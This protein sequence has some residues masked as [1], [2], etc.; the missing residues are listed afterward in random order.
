[1]KIFEVGGAVRDRLL[2]LPVKDH[3]YVVVGS[4]PQ[5]MARL[6]YTPVGKDFPVFLHPQTHEEYA[7]ARIERKSAPGYKGFQVYAAPDVTLEQDLSRRDFTI[8]AMARDADGTLVDPY[9]GQADLGAGVLRHVGTAF[10]ED[11]VR[12]LRGARFAARFGFNVAPETLALMRSMAASGEVDAL[13]P[14]RVWQE[15]AKGLMEKAPA[16]MFEVLAQ[17]GALD[18]IFPEAAARA[19]DLRAALKGLSHAVRCDFPLPVR[20][21]ACALGLAGDRTEA[22]AQRVKAPGD[23]RDLAVL[24]AGLHARI[25]AAETAAVEELLALLHAGDAFRRPERYAGLLDVCVCE[26]VR[27]TDAPAEPWPPRVRVELALSAAT[28]VDAGAVAKAGPSG[29]IQARVQAARLDA[30][31][32]ALAGAGIAPAARHN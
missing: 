23:C 7:L 11:P 9:G 18:A 19:G 4:T 30:V 27:A 26:M 10:A 13:V 24:A 25:A 16:R 20:F 5:E 32:A 31:R 6:G 29:D 22:L 3:D 17:C 12:I 2:G 15:L 8:N 1:M 21:A 14:E 28:A